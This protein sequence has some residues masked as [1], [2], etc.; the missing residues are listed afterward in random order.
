MHT[1]HTAHSHVEIAAMMAKAPRR[2][3]TPTLS[4]IIDPNPAP[5]ITQVLMRPSEEGYLSS[6]ASVSPN[7]LFSPDCTGDVDDD[8]LTATAVPNTP[9]AHPQCYR[10]A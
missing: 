8:E 5:P 2:I 1:R 10:V 3:L 9:Q 4:V 7:R 6:L